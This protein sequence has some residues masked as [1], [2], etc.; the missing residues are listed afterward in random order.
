MDLDYYLTTHLWTAYYMLSSVLS[1]L[2]CGKPEKVPEK[3]WGA[4][5]IEVLN[6]MKKIAIEL[7]H[8]IKLHTLKD[9]GRKESK[10]ALFK[11]LMVNTVGSQ[12]IFSYRKF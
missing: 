7:S 6:L 8:P 5:N 11:I 4:E 3:M 2:K 12:R 1:T 9:L 10:Y